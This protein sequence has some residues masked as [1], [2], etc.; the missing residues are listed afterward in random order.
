[1]QS[2]FI[3]LSAATAVCAA[4]SRDDLAHEFLRNATNTTSSALSSPTLWTNI[5]AGSAYLPFAALGLAAILVRHHYEERLTTVTLPQK[6]ARPWLRVLQLLVASFML[7]WA[8]F[9][10]GAVDDLF[11]TAIFSSSS[12]RGPDGSSIGLHCAGPVFITFLNRCSK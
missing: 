5:I 1:M 3:A 9:W 8:W 6:V 12:C 11:D 10:I 2:R 7:R 4:F